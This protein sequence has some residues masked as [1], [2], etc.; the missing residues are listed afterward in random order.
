MTII[1][2]ASNAS[3]A[4]VS[5]PQG[6]FQ[7]P[8]HGTLAIITDTTTTNLLVSSGSTIAIGPTNAVVIADGGGP[9]EAWAWAFILGFAVIATIGGTRVVARFLAVKDSSTWT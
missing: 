5:I 9:F 3:I 8:G 7:W 2:T 1:N 6:V 4:G